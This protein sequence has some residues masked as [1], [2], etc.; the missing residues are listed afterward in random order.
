MCNHVHLLL[1][2]EE[3]GGPAMLMKQVD[4]RYSQSFNRRRQRSGT[5]WEGRYYASAV[6]SDTYVLACY[7]Y[8]EQNP[9]RAGIVSQ[10]SEYRWSSHRENLGLEHP[11]FVVPHASFLALATPK[12]DAASVYRDLFEQPLDPTVLATIREARGVSRV[13]DRGLTRV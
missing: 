10:P 4:Q 3:D 12:R 13:P 5:L 7:R 2:P 9:M 1:T 11:L 6:D 8:I